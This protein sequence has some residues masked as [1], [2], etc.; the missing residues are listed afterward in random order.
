MTI[1]HCDLDWF[2]DLLE[3]MIPLKKWWLS[4]VCLNVAD[5]EETVKLMK[6]SGCKG[7]FCWHRVY[8]EGDP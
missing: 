4:Q 7:S 8:L 1:P 3:K 6:A 2:H 5:N